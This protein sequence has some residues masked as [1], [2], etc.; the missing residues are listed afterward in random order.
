MSTTS[1]RF[2]TAVALVFFFAVSTFA[3]TVEIQ[4]FSGKSENTSDAQ[5]I[6]NEAKEY[7]RNL[8]SSQR[9]E[10]IKEAKKVVKDFKQNKKQGKETDTDQLLL[11]IL[12]VLVPPLAVYLHEGEINGKFWLDL[13]LTLLFYLPGLIYALIVIL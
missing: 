4:K 12:A 10:N 7:F 5:T 8:S 13:L 9:K 2:I 6:E 11:V 3:T 1:T